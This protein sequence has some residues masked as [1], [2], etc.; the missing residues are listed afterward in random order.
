MRAV[1]SPT[2]RPRGRGGFT[3]IELLVV[4]AIIAILIGLLLPA[5]QKVRE[6][7]NRAEC[8][9]NLKQ[10]ALGYH[11][12]HDQ[13]GY[14]PSGGWGWTWIGDPDRGS[15]K[16]QP[17]GWLFSILPYVEQG[18]LYLQGAGGTAAQKATANYAKA[19]MP[20]KLFMCPT[21]RNFQAYVNSGNYG[22]VNAPT[23]SSMPVFAKADYAATCGSNNANEYNGGPPDLASGD[24]DNWWINSNGAAGYAS[25]FNGI[26]YPR[27]QVRIADLARGTS[28]FIMIGEKYLNPVDYKTGADPS[29]N[30]S[31][32]VGFDNDISRTTFYPPMQDLR[33]YRNTL[34]FGSAHISGLQ[35]GLADG[36]VRTVTYSV[37]PATWLTYGNRNSTAVSAF[38]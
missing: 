13:N 23:A 34:Q 33:G 31:M 26:I 38:N 1:F 22:Y 29:D 37:D 24:S 21:R 11:S 8:G 35:V 16:S 10:M 17:G 4:I 20:L 19:Q 18:S 7:A 5:V 12:C 25:T 32:Y 30:E 28:N 27:S 6:A 36:S 2:A 14:F 3:L 9:N 15:G